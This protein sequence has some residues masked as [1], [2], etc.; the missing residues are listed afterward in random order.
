M[1]RFEGIISLL[2]AVS[3]H[4]GAMFFMMESSSLKRD[5]SDVGDQ[6]NRRTAAECMA[7]LSQLAIENVADNAAACCGHLQGY[8]VI[9]T[10]VCCGV[11]ANRGRP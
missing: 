10:S 5:V 4:C 3:Q 9:F 2:A 6:V 11:S 1:L 7:M 8:K